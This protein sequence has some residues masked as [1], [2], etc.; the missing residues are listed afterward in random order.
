MDTHDPG[1]K[2]RTALPPGLK[3]AASFSPCRR[4]RHVLMRWAGTEFFPDRF[5][6]FVGMNPSTADEDANDPTV[7]REWRFAVSWGY[8][9]LVKVNVGDYRATSPADLSRPGVVPRSPANLEAIVHHAVRA[10]RIVL[11][12]GKVPRVLEGAA[13]ETVM[14]LQLRALD[15][16]CLGTNKDGSPKHPL[17]LRADTPL[18]PFPWRNP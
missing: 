15:L 7:S 16:W 18:E 2:V 9:G 13:E 11:A 17:Y 12:F 1:G 14:E 6:L 5:V 4:Y 3:G 8:A 10:D